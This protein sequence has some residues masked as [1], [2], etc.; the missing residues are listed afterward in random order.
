MNVI[1]GDFEP[2]GDVDVDD[3]MIMAGQWLDNGENLQSDIAPSPAD[4]TVNL[5]DFA[6]LSRHWLENTS[7]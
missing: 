3:L 5:K 2:D 6:E 1:P 4:G 7:L